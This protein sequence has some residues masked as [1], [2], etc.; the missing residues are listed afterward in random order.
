MLTVWNADPLIQREMLNGMH[1]NNA[2]FVCMPYANIFQDITL[3]MPHPGNC[4]TIPYYCHLKTTKSVMTMLII[5]LPFEKKDV[6][7]CLST[8]NNL[9]T[10]DN[11]IKQQCWHSFCNIGYYPP[12][13][14]IKYKFLSS[15]ARD[16]FLCLLESTAHS[17]E[18]AS[19]WLLEVAAPPIRWPSPLHHD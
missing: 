12:M 8:M 17:R 11:R 3:S 6:W 18:C 9:I 16:M 7:R 10:F 2:Y 14:K 15:P 4:Y 1:W 5:S 13:T 19:P